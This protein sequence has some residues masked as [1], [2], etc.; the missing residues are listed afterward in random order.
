MFARNV[1]SKLKANSAPEFT[2][3][4]QNEILPL[5]RKQKGFLDEILFVAPERSEALVIS[6]WDTKEDAETYGRTG[7][8]E[9]LKI[10]SKVYEGTPKLETFEVS[11]STFQKFAA[12]GV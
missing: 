2:R 4:I 12:K 11:Q 5:F 7:Y 1:T 8:P 9:A 6:F 3:L 10:M